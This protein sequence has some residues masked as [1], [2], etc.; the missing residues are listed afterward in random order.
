MNELFWVLT[1]ATLVPAA[2]GFAAVRKSGRPFT[3]EAGIMTLSAVA[4]AAAGYTSIGHFGDWQVRTADEATDWQLAARLTEA[5]R[6]AKAETADAASLL[7]LAQAYYD[8][9]KYA[10]AV[11]VLTESE[12]R[13]GETSDA[14]ALKAEA[15][16]YREGRKLTAEV[17]ALTDRVLAANPYQVPVRLLLAN[18]AFL[19]ERWTE[20][21]REWE[22]LLQSG[23]V[24]GR[25]RAIE[26]AIAKAR[27][28]R[29]M[30][31]KTNQ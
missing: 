15:L 5:R 24:K 20:A 8:G 17:K 3:K 31:S 22:F 29:N 10:E 11:D 28:R 12:S 4:V 30:A 18:D 1:G 2:A 25:E 7:T 23:A 26:N 16:Y 9:G 13:F 27:Y 21:I 19:N 14:A 6:A